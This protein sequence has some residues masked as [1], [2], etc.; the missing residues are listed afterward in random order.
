MQKRSASLWSVNHS[1]NDS[2][3][4]DEKEEIGNLLDTLNTIGN[5]EGAKNGENV[6]FDIKIDEKKSD[7]K[8]SDEEKSDEEKSDE[9]K[10]DDNDEKGLGNATRFKQQSFRNGKDKL[11][12]PILPLHFERTFFH[13]TLDMYIKAQSNSSTCIYTKYTHMRLHTYVHITYTCINTH[14]P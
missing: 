13:F 6:S 5:E 2:V 1:A 4:E 10:S 7:E 8:K 9:E 14:S 11:H 12:S 3:D